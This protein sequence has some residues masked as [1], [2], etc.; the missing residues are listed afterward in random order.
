[1]APSVVCTEVS[2]R[3]STR[4]DGFPL[5]S[6]YRHKVD[7]ITARFSP[8]FVGILKLCLTRVGAKICEKPYYKGFSHVY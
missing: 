7:H 1:M 6:H 4:V 5:Y 3:T 8:L 2:A